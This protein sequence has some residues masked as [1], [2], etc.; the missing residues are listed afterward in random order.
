M[1][2]PP[3][4]A[5]N[6]SYDGQ[7]KWLPEIFIIWGFRKSCLPF[8]ILHV[9]ADIFSIYTCRNLL[10]SFLTHFSQSNRGILDSSKNFIA[11]STILNETMWCNSWNIRRKNESTIYKLINT[12]QIGQIYEQD[13]FCAKRAACI[14]CLRF[15]DEPLEKRGIYIS[16]TLQKVRETFKM[17]FPTN[18]F[19]QL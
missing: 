9:L 16:E 8:I 10:V 12:F 7:Q 11:Y 18:L 13:W 19:Y 4:R 17:L 3:Q 1:V 2:T 5:L 6:E 14:L 15:L